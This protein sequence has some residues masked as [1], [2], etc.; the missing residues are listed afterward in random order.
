LIIT[1][2]KDVDMQLR[3]VI[4]RI[5]VEDN[6]RNLDIIARNSK[7]YSCS[8]SEVINKS[9]FILLDTKNIKNVQKKCCMLKQKYPFSV[10]Y[11]ISD[12]YHQGILYVNSICDVSGCVI[13]EDDM[14]IEHLQV[15]FKWIDSKKVAVNDALIWHQNGISQIIPYAYIDYIETVKGEHYC[16]INCDKKQLKIRCS[17]R[18]LKAILG[19]NFVQVKSS[20]LVNVSHIEMLYH[21]EQLIIFHNKGSCHYSESHKKE[22]MNHIGKH[23]SS[24]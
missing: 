6:L 9:L 12:S 22:L 11:I 8:D 2:E 18:E 10:I 14:W 20:I 17:I 19:N 7:L 1:G 21:R 4:D 23:C 24:I 3:Q 5:I 16:M 13:F 15:A